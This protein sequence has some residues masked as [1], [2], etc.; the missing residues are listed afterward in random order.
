MQLSSYSKL[1]GFVRRIHK[2]IRSGICA[3]IDRICQRSCPEVCQRNCQPSLP[4][5]RLDL[6]DPFEE[7]HLGYLLSRDLFE[8]LAHF[9]NFNGYRYRE[10]PFLA[11]R[12]LTSKK[13]LGGSVGRSARISK[14]MTTPKTDPLK[15]NGGIA[16]RSDHS[17]IQLL[18]KLVAVG[19]VNINATADLFC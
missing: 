5:L 18:R 10:L 8:D 12:P 19:S 9:G 2:R 17:S 6:E 13:T 4:I 14:K 16:G 7:L 3:S 1:R 11:G 15:K